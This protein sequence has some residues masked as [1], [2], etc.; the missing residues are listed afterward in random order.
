VMVIIC[1]RKV[2][3]SVRKNYGFIRL[4]VTEGYGGLQ[5]AS[6]MTTRTPRL[7]QRNPQALT[8][9]NALY[10]PDFWA[11]P[12]QRE[13]D[14]SQ[15]ELGITRITEDANLEKIDFIYRILLIVNL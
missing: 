8:G 6:A 10:Y 14:S 1:I 2:E 15:V 5:G 7:L 12:S 11:R 9:P 4:I 13:H 3:K